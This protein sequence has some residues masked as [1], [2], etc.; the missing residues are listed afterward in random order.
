M[1][2]WNDDFL[3]YHFF[4]LIKYTGFLFPLK[5]KVNTNLKFI[6]WLF[7]FIGWLIDLFL[8]KYVTRC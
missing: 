4:C 6:Y 5:L 8:R 7:F 2:F 1:L 3:K